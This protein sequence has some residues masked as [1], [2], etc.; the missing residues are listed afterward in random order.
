MA[1]ILVVC[2]DKEKQTCVPKE[3]S[4]LQAPEI[5]MN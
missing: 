1:F 5:T 2:F 4:I 3:S